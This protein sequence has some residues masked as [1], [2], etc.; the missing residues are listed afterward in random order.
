MKKLFLTIG[1]LILVTSLFAQ[2]FAVVD[3]D[4]IL[5]NIPEYELAQDRIND[6]AV[7]WQKEIEKK[8]AEIEEMYRA[9]QAEAVLLPAD[10]K[11]KREEQIIA[12]ERE[13]KE[14]QRKRFGSDGDLTRRRQ[15]LIK[16]IQ[17]RI[18]NAIEEI[19]N[20]SNFAVVFDKAGALSMLY[21]NPR[22]DI[23]DDVLQA[24]GYGR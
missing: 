17:D 11:K 13:A 8:F 23:S 12:K 22:N 15:E 24:L 6:Q 2:R 18:Y 14:L 7:E 4:Y 3:T 19:A 5:S 16:P 20:R 1:C 21:V 10:E 9:Y